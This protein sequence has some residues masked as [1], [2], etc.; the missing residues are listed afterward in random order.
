M[1]FYAENVIQMCDGDI[2]DMT[3]FCENDTM[4]HVIDR[5]SENVKTE[6][7]DEGHF[8][9]YVRVPASPTFF[10]RVFTFQGGIKITAPDDVTQIYLAGIEV[11]FCLFS[12]LLPS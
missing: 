5:F 2:R 7:I 10:A 11:T 8:A 4:K 1:A 6:I 12:H 3:L 9:A